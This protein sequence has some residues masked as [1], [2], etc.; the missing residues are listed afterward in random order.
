MSEGT[1]VGSVFFKIS[2]NRGAFTKEMKTTASGVQN[3]FGSAMKAVGKSIGVAFSVAAVVSFGKKCVQVASETQSAWKGLSSIIN[4]QGKDFGRANAFI[5]DYI[6]DGLVP[7][8][9]AVTA[10]KNLAARGYDQS[11]IESVMNALKDSAAFG[12]QASL[13]YGDAIQS[14]TEGLKNENSV[15]VDN[16]GVTKNVSKMWEEYAKSIGTTSASL[17]QQQKIQAE[18]NG[19]LQETRWQTGDAA[20]YSHTFAGGIARISATSTQLKTAIGNTLIPVLNQLLPLIQT[21][22]E[23]A[24]SFCNAM[25]SVMA[26]LGWEMPDVSDFSA[27]IGSVSTDAV[28]AAAATEGVGTAAETA[29]KKAKK[30]FA[31]FDEINVL[32]TQKSDTSSAGNSGGMANT[33]FSSAIPPKNSA[34]D[35]T[36]MEKQIANITNIVST[37]MLAIG[38]ILTFTGANIPLGVAL[39][40]AGA[41]GIAAALAIDWNSTADSV[42]SAVDVVAAIISG[43]LLA[44]GA[45]LTFSG[46]NLPLGIALLAVGAAGMATTIALNWDSPTNSCKKTVEAIAA[47]V[48]GAFLAIGALLA[49]TGANI[50]LGIALLAIGA[51]SSVAAIAMNWNSLDGSVSGVVTTITTIVGGALLGLGAVLAFSGANIPLGIALMATGAVTLAASIAPNWNSVSD[52]TKNTISVIA[53]I[54]GGAMLALGVLLLFSGAGIPLGLGLIGAGAASLAA[55]IAP[56]WNTITA[57]VDGICSNISASASKLWQNIKNTFSNVGSWFHEKFTSARTSIENVFSNIGNFFGNIWATIKSN[58]TSIGT[59][60]GDAVG[61]AFKKAVNSVLATIENV[62]NTPIR[63]INSLLGVINK[64]PGINLGRLNEFSLP[65]LAQGGWVAA[66]NPQLAIIGDNKREG[67]IVTPESK[68][69]EQVEMALAKFGGMVQKVKLELEILIR[70]PDGRTIIKRINEAQIAEGRILLE[71]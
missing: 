56:N 66:N 60:I 53:G 16:A 35:T 63:A 49:F 8:N 24:L 69:R 54:A 59:K 7:L 71:V 10:Y 42:S 2:S 64:V 25:Q 65:R 61:V 1:N 62:A 9:N 30:A 44:V 36:E 11:Q 34:F 47:V 41:V 18:V 20:K 21:G 70:Y 52:K 27:A 29:A 58:F 6:K 55:A 32:N 28:N 19:I 51:A 31:S 45:I 13:S 67:E 3:S 68:I 26:S 4:G 46:A 12:R 43:A 40:A 39:M 14:A 57:K 37:A 33:A 15:L 5:Q 48:G 23:L 22:L 50:P 38:A 17:T